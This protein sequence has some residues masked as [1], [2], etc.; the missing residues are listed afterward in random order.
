MNWTRTPLSV[1]PPSQTRH[2]SRPRGPM[3]ICSGWPAVLSPQASRSIL[4]YRGMTARMS[5][6]RLDSAFAR[7]PTAS[8]SP[9]SLAKG[10]ISAATMRIL[11]ACTGMPL[12]EFSP[13]NELPRSLLRGIRLDVMPSMLKGKSLFLRPVKTGTQN[14]MLDSLLRGS[15][16][17]ETIFGK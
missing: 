3:G 5:I 7:A 17:V 13:W 1:R 10:A 11:G 2:S 4:P 12:F 8:P 14:Y 6:P 15:D 16:R 9:P